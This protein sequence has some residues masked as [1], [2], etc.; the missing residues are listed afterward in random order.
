MV[1]T[2]FFYLLKNLHFWFSLID[3]IYFYLI[4]SVLSFFMYQPNYHLIVCMNYLFTL[5]CFFLFFLDI[6]LV[7]L[8]DRNQHQISLNF[9]IHQKSIYSLC[10][11]NLNFQY[12]S[13][14]IME[15]LHYFIW[16]VGFVWNLQKLFYPNLWMIFYFVH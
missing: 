4:L 8:F 9:Q 3:G 15:I 2:W 1:S 16:I 10:H 7:L 14:E 6:F 11:S 12:F 5:V 13:I